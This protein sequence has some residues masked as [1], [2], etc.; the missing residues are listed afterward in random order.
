MDDLLDGEDMEDLVYYEC[1]HPGLDNVRQARR[2]QQRR[3][4]LTTTATS[5][6]TETATS[7]STET[8]GTNV[9]R[10]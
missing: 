2:E 9:V 1:I 10:Q 3:Q 6:S 4:R 7:P 8:T 5:P